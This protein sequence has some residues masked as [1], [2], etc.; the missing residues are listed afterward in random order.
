MYFCRKLVGIMAKNSKWQ[1]DYW[2]LLMQL[3]LQ[4]PVGLKPMYSRRMVE[5]SLEIHVSGRPMARIR[6]NW[7]VLP[8]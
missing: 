7:P 5:L 4:K 8:V 2:L 3:Y 1:D 6:R